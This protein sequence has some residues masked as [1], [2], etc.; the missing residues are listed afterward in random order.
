LGLQFSDGFRRVGRLTAVV[1]GDD[2]A[3]RRLDAL[4]HA[5][6][7]AG[8]SKRGLNGDVAFRKRVTRSGRGASGRI[9]HKLASN[10]LFFHSTS[11]SVERVSLD[12]ITDIKVGE[13]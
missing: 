10:S 6:R 8:W 1:F 13:S 7:V 11:D 9:E 2:L 5:Q 4:C 12:A 3:Q